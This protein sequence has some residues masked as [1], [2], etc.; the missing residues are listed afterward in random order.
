MCLFPVMLVYIILVRC[1][2]SKSN[3]FDIHA[4]VVGSRMAG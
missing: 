2:T 4:Y 3:I 1:L